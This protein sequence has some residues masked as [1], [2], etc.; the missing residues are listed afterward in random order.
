MVLLGS[1]GLALLSAGC[2]SDHA[3]VPIDAASD[4]ASDAGASDAGS[5]DASFPGPD[6]ASADAALDRCMGAPHCIYATFTITGTTSPEGPFDSLLDVP[7]TYLGTFSELDEISRTSFN[8][9]IV[10][11][12]EPLVSTFTGVDDPVIDLLEA[13][14]RA[15]FALLVTAAG[16]TFDVFG[17]DAVGADGATYTFALG[18]GCPISV[19]VDPE[20]YPR[21]EPFIVECQ[22]V[23]TRAEGGSMER[24]FGNATIEFR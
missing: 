15:G 9:R 22:A 23:F 11:S 16:P 1:M 24:A 12:A 4:A 14:T 20:G 3:G 5:L 18:T 17:L 13:N 7:S 2:G 21:Y 6:A 19:S 8:H 10:A